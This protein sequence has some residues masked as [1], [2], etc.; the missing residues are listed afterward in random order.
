MKVTLDNKLKKQRKT[1][2][3]FS[4]KK[5]EMNRKRNENLQNEQMSYM[6]NQNEKNVNFNKGYED[7][8]IISPAADDEEKGS[9]DEGSTYISFVLL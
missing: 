6:N 8:E 5:N 2:K 1:A 3:F 9:A 7:D 4:Q